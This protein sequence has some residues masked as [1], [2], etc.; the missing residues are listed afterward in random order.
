[1]NFTY[2]AFLF[3]LSAI[4]IP[5]IIHLFNFR[6]FKTIYFSNVKFLK[7]VQQETQSKSKLK[8]LLVLL[9]RILAIVFLVFAF[10]QPYIPNNNKS[11]VV[12]SSVISVFIDNSFSMDAVNTNGTLLDDAKKRA[13][14]IIAAYKPSDRF[15]II[16]NDFEG[17]HQ[18]LINREEFI[19]RLDEIRI[20]PVSRKFSEI[21]SRVADI[22][23]SSDSKNKQ[24]Y[25]VSDF[26]K[27]N[28]DIDAYKVDTSI[29]I[30][31]IPIQANENSNV[32]IDTCWFENPVRQLG[33]NEKLHVRLKN[34][35]DKTFENNSIKLFI[36]G[37]QKTPASFTIE[38]ESETEVVLAFASKETGIQHCW[39]EINDY[40]ITFDDKF[41]FSFD[42]AKSITVLSVNAA[43]NTTENS[44]LNKL[45]ASDSGFVFKS[46][47]ENQIDYS[48]LS[49]NNLILLNQ[50]KTIST[51]LAQELQRFVS[52]GGSLMVIPSIDMD[53]N[54]YNSFL[55]LLR[56]NNYQQL[57]TA[58]T[59]V[60]N[61]NIQS[62]IYKDVFDKKTFS[63]SNLDLPKVFQHY[64]ISKNSRSTEEYLMKLQNGNVFLGKYQS[65]KGLVY[66]LSVPINEKYSNFVKHAIF[67][68]TLYKIAI[69]SQN[70]TPLFYTIGNNQSIEV[71]NV[72]TGENVFRLKNINSDFEIIP[73][74]KLIDLKMQLLVN[75]Q[76][77]QA[78]NYN[79]SADKTVIA[80]VSFNYN[81]NESD[82]NCNSSEQLN[83]LISQKGYTNM[84]LIEPSK[85]SL[86]QL[87]AETEQGTKLWK[88]CIILALVF[89]GAEIALLRFLK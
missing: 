35:S 71:E 85:Q 74:H 80:G 63:A 38:A 75:N 16:T 17:K 62:E 27:S 70:S 67:V 5:I 64:S 54:S 50:L 23:N 22:M 13:N 8:H 77:S 24:L 44:Y 51:G 28:F 87:L 68:P 10:A 52:N 78:G 12:G 47:P 6:K 25:V 18:R 34:S 9:A 66:L 81:R 60:D 3:A 30:H 33:A 49:K 43:S 55:N 37:N 20:S 19:E 29:N 41:Y 42:V 26:Q 89:L 82:L 2:P 46:T 53:L 69:Q 40:P 4:A 83:S 61:I 57:D 65:Q 7:S 88:L 48:A 73:E 59:K 1:M 45:F 79:V 14:E 76:I 72:L 15:Q 21:S 84:N 58:R 11:Q 86:T 32:Y 56:I 36:N 39:V 31:L